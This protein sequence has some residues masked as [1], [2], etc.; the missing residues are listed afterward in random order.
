MSR[1]ADR[2]L[3]RLSQTRFSE[4]F[5]ARVR[6]RLMQ[7]LR[8]HPRRRSGFPFL[9]LAAGFAVVLLALLGTGTAYAQRALPGETFYPW[10]L[11]SENAWRAVSSDPVGAD[12]VIAERRVDE[13]TVVSDD[14]ALRAQTLETYLETVAR[15]RSEAGAQDEIRIV[16]TLDSQAAVLKKLGILLA[17]PTP[18]IL[19]SEESASTPTASPMPTVQTPGL[20]PTALPSLTP[21]V[22]VP[23]EI[24]PTM[25][26]PPELVPTFEIPPPVR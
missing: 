19:P 12:L 25:D 20:D 3:E 21:T 10:K 13:L 1:L 11:A 15:L 24:F 23:P 6:T 5:Q 14:P 9:R 16:Q 8:A 2:Q 17:R 7:E 26:I 18:D 22:E 4:A